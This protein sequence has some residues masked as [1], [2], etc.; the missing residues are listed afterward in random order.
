MEENGAS[1]F[2]LLLLV[3]CQ[4]SYEV[5]GL[6]EESGSIKSQLIFSKVGEKLFEVEHKEL[7]FEKVSID[8][9][10]H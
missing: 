2:E 9:G 3:V 6:E 7:G 1:S 10:H 5:R 8:F 4:L